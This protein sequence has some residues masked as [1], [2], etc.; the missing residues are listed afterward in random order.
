MQGWVSICGTLPGCAYEGGN[1]E[2]ARMVGL[3][4]VPSDLWRVGDREAPG[5]NLNPAGF[6]GQGAGNS[7]PAK[8]NQPMARA[9]SP[10]VNSFFPPWSCPW[11]WVWTGKGAQLHLRED[12]GSL[13]GADSL[14]LS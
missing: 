12:S 5:V 10:D 4:H 7:S 13:V 9:E 1:R 11:L 2:E 3:L 14:I 6:Q 8:D